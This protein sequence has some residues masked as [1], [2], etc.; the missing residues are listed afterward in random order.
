MAVNWIIPIVITN[1]ANENKNFYAL[2]GQSYE[3]FFMGIF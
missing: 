2:S 3:V 1:V